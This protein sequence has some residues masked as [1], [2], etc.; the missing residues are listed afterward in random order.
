MDWKYLVLIDISGIH[1]YIFG[2]NKLREIRGA[3]ILLDSLTQYQQS[4]ML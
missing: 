2:T 1:N 4:V 3:S